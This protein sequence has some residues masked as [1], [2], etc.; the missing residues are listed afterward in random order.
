MIVVILVT[1]YH[2]KQWLH[3]C[4]D[5]VKKLSTELARYKARHLQKDEIIQHLA[6]ENNQM[7]S[8]QP[9]VEA[10]MEES[11][12]TLLTI[13][14]KRPS[15]DSREEGIIPAGT[16]RKADLLLPQDPEDRRCIICLADFTRNEKLV[17]LPCGHIFRPVCNERWMKQ[18]SAVLTVSA[19]YDGSWL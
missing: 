7:R 17:V 8:K 5:K 16:I 15:D 18:T 1:G 10:Y 11:A 6:A 2:L 19:S 12:H 14:C 13:V 3:Q 9:K 4:N